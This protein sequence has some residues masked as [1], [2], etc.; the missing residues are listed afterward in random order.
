MGGM[1]SRPWWAGTL[2]GG[3]N[4]HFHG[5]QDANQRHKPAVFESSEK[6]TADLKDAKAEVKDKL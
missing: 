6:V 4:P 5:A 2:T 3:N 1:G